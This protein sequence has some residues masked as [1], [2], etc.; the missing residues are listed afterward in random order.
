M[1][2][3]IGYVGAIARHV[4]RRQSLNNW[5]QPIQRDGELYFPN[6]D[7]A[8]QFTNPNF[9]QIEWMSSDVNTSYNALTGNLQKQFGMGMTYQASYTYSKCIDDSSSSETNYTTAA[10]TGQWSPDRSLETARCNFNVPHSFVF[11]GLYELPFGTGRA[12]M[13][14]G[15]IADIILGGWQVGGVVTIQQ[16]T[17][18]TVSTNSRNAGYSF[19]ANRPN[20]NPGVDIKEVTKGEFGNREQYFDATAFSNPPAGR[21]GN[22]SRNI[23]LGPPLVQTNFT[24]SK[25]FSVAEQATVQFRGEFFNLFNQTN[26]G[27]PDDNVNAAGAGRI[28]S[29][30]TKNRQIQFAL[31]LVF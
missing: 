30:S 15:G 24:L 20:V 31:K 25:T 27:F 18:F 26:L 19:N 29:T 28:D 23:L 3:R 13:N 6:R 10:T 16:G 7:E 22:A 8:P 14:S 12:M 17:P 4:A 2:G 11:N 1:A 5:P 21:L 9:S